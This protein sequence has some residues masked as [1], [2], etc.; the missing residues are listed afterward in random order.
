MQLRYDDGYHYQNIFGP[1]VRLEGDED[2]VT[3]ESWR[4]DSVV[5][6]WD[7][8]LNTRRLARFRFSRPDSEVWADPVRVCLLPVRV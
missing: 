8:A 3:K 7:V 6:R 5:V 2:R 4:Q 1:L